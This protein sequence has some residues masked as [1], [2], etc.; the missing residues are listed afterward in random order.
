MPSILPE[1]PD[2]WKDGTLTGFKVR[3]G[4]TVNLNRADGYP[5]EMVIIGGWTESQT[6][7]IPAG[8]SVTVNG[9]HMETRDGFLV[10]P[11]R[12]KPWNLKFD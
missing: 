8:M 7:K 1:L 9:Q 2:E 11:S 10:L 5:T 3:G 6:I 4:A 12:R